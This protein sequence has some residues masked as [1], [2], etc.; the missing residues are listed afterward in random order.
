MGKA[1]HTVS[2]FGQPL[3]TWND[4]MDRPDTWRSL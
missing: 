4:L 1:I 2:D 3:M